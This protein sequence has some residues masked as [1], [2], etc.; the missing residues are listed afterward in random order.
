MKNLF[1]IALIVF[2][3]CNNKQKEVQ[4]QVKLLT[5]A[6]YASGTLVPE[7]EYTVKSSIDGFLTTVNVR[8]GDEVR[9]GTWLFSVT[10]EN[11]RAAVTAAE[12]SVRTTAPLASANAPA[13]RE[14]QNHL[15]AAA[16]KLHSDS[17]QYNRYSNL[18]QQDAVSKSLYEKYQ[19]QYETSARE[20]AAIKA[21]MQQVKL[22]SGIQLQ[23]ATDQL[24]LSQT[25]SG[26]GVVRSF[27][28][29]RVYDVYY[30][31]GDLILPNQPIA[32]IGSGQMIAR[33]SVDEDDLQRVQ[34]GQKVQI[35]LDAFPDSIFSATIRRIY[36][37]LNRVE[38]SFRVDAYFN[39]PVPAAMYGLNVE[40]NIILRE[41]QKTTV[42]PRK[43]IRKGDSI[44]VKQNNETITLKVHTG[45]SDKEWVEIGEGIV[46][47]NNIIILQ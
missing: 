38:Q 32:L 42:V 44:E 1:S 47:T 5:E 35:T 41:K 15:S 13:L 26:T 37:L 46:S 23:Q 8:E 6:V 11:A 34:V 39:S 30:K 19:L 27:N 14:L 43:A 29:G 40:A 7:I 28:D 25:R 36:P 20:V 3:S 45:A 16:T 31:R 22:T 2:I 9:V 24:Q 12:H 18:F 10:N 17:L 21:Q 4:P 33:L